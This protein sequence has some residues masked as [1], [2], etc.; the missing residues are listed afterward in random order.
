[1]ELPGVV[2]TALGL[3]EAG[4]EAIHIYVHPDTPLDQVRHQA[5]RL[6]SGAPIVVMAMEM[7]E[8]D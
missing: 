2:G 5:Q 7:P 8:A 3:D 4:Q 1:M 6:L